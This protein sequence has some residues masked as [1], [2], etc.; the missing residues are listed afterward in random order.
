MEKLKALQHPY[1]TI[2]DKINKYGY[3]PKQLH[4]ILRMNDFIKKYVRGE[5]YKD[6]LIPDNKEYLIQIKKG[7][8]KEQEAVELATKIDEETKIIKD[9]NIKEQDEIDEKAIE[10]LDLTKFKILERKFK[11]E[12]V[13]EEK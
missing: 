13:K 10:I 11:N 7:I 9:E 3:D 5:N 8:L 4:H 1:P 6:C 12:L 2:I